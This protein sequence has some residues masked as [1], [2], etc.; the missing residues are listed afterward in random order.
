MDGAFK[1]SA[2]RLGGVGAWRWPSL[3]AREGHDEECGATDGCSCGHGFLASN[4]MSDTNRHMSLAIATSCLATN[5]VSEPP[6][7][8]T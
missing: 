3:A 7:R 2:L 4:V 5:S 1:S 8:T 6:L